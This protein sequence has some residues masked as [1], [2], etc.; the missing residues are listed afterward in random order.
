MTVASAHTEHLRPSIHFAPAKNWMNDPNGLILLDGVWHLFFQHNPNGSR[1]GDIAWGHAS[2]TDLATW[3]EHPVAIAGDEHEMIFSG[4]IVHDVHDT[5]GLGGGAGPLVAIYTSHYV[6]HPVHGTRQAQSIAHSLDHGM[7][8]TTY[9]GNPVDDRDRPDYR[10]P[11][12]FWHDGPDGGR[13]IMVA[14]EADRSRL[15]IS[16]SS[17]LRT[18]RE[19]STFETDTVPGFWECPDLFPLPLDGGGERWVLLLSTG[20]PN[21]AYVVGEFDGVRFVEEAAPPADLERRIAEHGPD[22]YAAVTFAGV[23]GRRVMIGWMGHA[24]EAPTSPW[25][26]IMTAPRE[27]SL[28]TIDGCARLSSRFARELDPPRSATIDVDVRAAALVELPPGALRVRSEFDAVD[29][30]G[31]RLRGRGVELEIS[32]ADGRVVVRRSGEPYDGYDRPHSAA[33]APGV[34]IVRLDVLV[35]AM[36]VE[37]LVGDGE[38]VFSELLFGDDGLRLLEPTA[39]AA[40][41][42]LTIAEIRPAPA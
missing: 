19:L 36:S 35:D 25:R 23:T 22:N 34:P 20:G 6:D 32:I 14:V 37:V 1:W 8:W 16:G 33:L 2:S 7:T 38:I 31:L 21:Q 42:R 3:T 39:A 28:R 40:H 17:D 9:A 10:D 4:S 41:R 18:W 29:G 13:W 5:S 11:K 12:V 30:A 26:G 24:G 27:L 15:V